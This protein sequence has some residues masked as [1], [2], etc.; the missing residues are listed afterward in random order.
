MQEETRRSGLNSSETQPWECQAGV[1]FLCKEK[2]LVL[3]TALKDFPG[4]P[5]VIQVHALTLTSLC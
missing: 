5:V 3:D 2:I 4:H 1:G